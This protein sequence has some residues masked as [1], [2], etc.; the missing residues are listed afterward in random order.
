MFNEIQQ[1]LLTL[2]QVLN[3]E[4]LDFANQMDRKEGFDPSREF[5]DEELRHFTSRGPVA[6]KKTGAER[7]YFLL[8][9][10]VAVGGKNFSRLYLR[11]FDY[12]S[13]GHKDI[14]ETF[15]REELLPVLKGYI[16][17]PFSWPAEKIALETWP[18]KVIRLEQNGTKFTIKGVGGGRF[19]LRENRINLRGESMDFGPVPH[20]YQERLKALFG[21]LC[22]KP[23]YQ[24]FQPHF[25]EINS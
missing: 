16:E 12:S 6:L 1:K 24:G 5:S 18:Y 3:V 9:V 25:E 15:L 13:M 19:D 7:K 8:E 14:G 21:L 2:D 17:I 10:A 22:Q 20:E 4:N 11:G 23:A